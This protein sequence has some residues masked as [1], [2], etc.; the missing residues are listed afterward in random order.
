MFSW[1][2][3][4][5]LI[6][7]STWG[8][9]TQDNNKQKRDSC[10]SRS[11]GGVL[12]RQ[13]SSAL[14][15]MNCFE[16]KSTTSRSH[17]AADLQ[18]FLN[19][20]GVKDNSLGTTQIFRESDGILESS[21]RYIEWMERKKREVRRCFRKMTLRVREGHSKAGKIIVKCNAK[22][23]EAYWQTSQREISVI[24]K[25]SYM[26]ESRSSSNSGDSLH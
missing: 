26:L 19:G 11:G 1:S 4:T 3:Q 16:T 15:K 9:R 25:P 22:I 7:S 17:P 21:Y 5:C 6:L 12:V 20:N 2:T 23:G 14:W 13:V 18:F 8:Q 24:S 10:W